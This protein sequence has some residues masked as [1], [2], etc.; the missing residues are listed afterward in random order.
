[1]EYHYRLA[2]SLFLSQFKSTPLINDPLVPD[3]VWLTGRGGKKISS[4]HGSS[5]LVRHAF[6]CLRSI[7]ANLQH[8][9]KVFSFQSCHLVWGS[10][11]LAKG[12]GLGLWMLASV[13]LQTIQAAFN[14]KLAVSKMKTKR[15]NGQNINLMHQHSAFAQSAEY[16]TCVDNENCNLS[17]WIRVW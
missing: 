13:W 17:S 15:D 10:L 16:M 12:R 3:C 14:V 5:G 2:L 11:C 9:S 1:M 7:P 4:K 6:P 8:E